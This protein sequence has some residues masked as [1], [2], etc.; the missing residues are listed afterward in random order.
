MQDLKIYGINIGAVAFSFITDINPILQTIVLIMTI[1]TT[2]M[3]ITMLIIITVSFHAIIITK[4][5]RKPIFEISNIIKKT[6]RK[7][8]MK[9][10]L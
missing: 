4:F 2:S 3:I 5:L 10:H 1:E 8:S 7:I 6:M 9:N